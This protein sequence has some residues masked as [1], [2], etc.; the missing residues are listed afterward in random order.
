MHRRL[1]LGVLASLALPGVAR[2][3]YPDRIIRIVVPFP[4]GGTTDILARLVADRLDKRFGQHAIIDNRP[5]ASG[6]IGTKAVAGAAPD[7]YTLV[8]ATTN[9]HGINV[10]VFKSLPYDPVRDF[11]PVTVVASTPN[12]LLVNPASGIADLAAL[13]RLAKEKPGSLVFGSTSTGGSPHMSGELLKVM[14]GIEMTHV[15]YRGGGPMLNDLI[16]GHIKIGFDNLPSAIGHVRAGTLRAL[17]VTTAERFP[18][19]PDVPTMAEAGVPGF[20]VPAWFGLLAPAGTPRPVIDLLQSRIAAVL[21]EPETR[22]R[23]LE[24]GGTPGGMSPDA[25]GEIVRREVAR[26]PAVVARTGVAIE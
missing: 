13:I 16:A 19:L 17:A 1:C 20:D 18:T 5:G 22:A 6:N 26:W 14:A 21:A 8:M 24:L 23:L 4:P 12:V 15:P 7:G 2:A 10:A 9:T 25:F 3:A 11:A